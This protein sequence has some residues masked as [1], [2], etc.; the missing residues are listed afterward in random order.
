M[1]DNMATITINKQ[2]LNKF[3]MAGLFLIFLFGLFFGVLSY[4]YSAYG[5]NNT[6]VLVR[7]NITNTEPVLYNVIVNND[8]I[9]LTPGANT[10]VN[11]T[12][13]VW[14]YNGWQDIAIV[15]AS[16]FRNSTAVGVNAADDRN[17]HYSNKTCT[18]CVQYLGTSTNASC[19]CLFSVDYYADNGTWECNMTVFD[20]YGVNSSNKT[21]F[22]VNPLLALSTPT[23]IDYGNLVVT[24]TSP[25]IGL[26]IT[27]V[28]NIPLN[29]T[30]RSHAGIDDTDSN[31]N[32]SLSCL[33]GNMS[34]S[35]HR[36]TINSSLPFD[37]MTPFSNDSVDVGNF[38]LHQRTSDT[39]YSSGDRNSTYFQLRVP[40]TVGGYC[41]GTV[42]FNA[43]S[44][45]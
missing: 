39:N 10:T 24:Q 2:V 41:N 34:F 16:I 37:S 8:P 45:S 38:T 18:P 4:S 6:S 27:N 23:E 30:L 36:W 17:H 33:F 3:S 21:Q 40:L 28:G 31:Q 25:K 9:D 44:A 20:T 32:W 13:L 15:N 22:Q 1:D 5:A 7:V 43:V 11:C 14:D 26:N 35:Q 29:L 12:G 19:S 42:Y